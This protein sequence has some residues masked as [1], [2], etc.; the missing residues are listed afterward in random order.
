MGFN[1]TLVVLNDALEQISEDKEFGQKVKASILRKYSYRDE[2]YVNI[3]SGNHANVAA[4]VGVHHADEKHLFA[5]G[6]NIGWDF[7]YMGGY[8]ATEEQMLRAW[9]AKLGFVL[10][11]KAKR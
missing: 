2:D 11:R 10:H 9:A 5:I 1:S 6:G 3:S 8:R 4:V 7:G